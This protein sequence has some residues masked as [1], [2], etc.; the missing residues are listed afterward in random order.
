M[1]LQ[2]KPITKNMY[3]LNT[4]SYMLATAGKKEESIAVARLNVLL[5]PDDENAQ[6]S[7]DARMK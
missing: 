7:L 3:D 4:Y 2:L 6:K 1:I 5:F